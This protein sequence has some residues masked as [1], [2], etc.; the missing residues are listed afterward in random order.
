M[1]FR[2]G[3]GEEFLSNCHF[4]KRF[5]NSIPT[6]SCPVLIGL[7]HT[8]LQKIRIFPVPKCA[9][10]REIRVFLYFSTENSQKTIKKCH[11]NRENKVHLLNQADWSL[12]EKY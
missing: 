3:F 6:P 5:V 2:W 10:I 7:T 9:Q 1:F 8:T 4:K 12:F 11:Q